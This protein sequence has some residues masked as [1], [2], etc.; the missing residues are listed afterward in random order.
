M[1]SITNYQVHINFLKFGLDEWIDVSRE[2]GRRRVTHAFTHTEGS[3]DAHVREVQDAQFRVKLNKSGCKVFEVENDGNCLFRAVALQILGDVS[4][5]A[6]VRKKC[7]EHLAKHRSHFKNFVGDDKSFDSYVFVCCFSLS[8]SLFLSNTHTHTHTNRYLIRM[9][10]DCVWGGHLEIIAMEEIWDRQIMIYRSDDTNDVPKPQ[11][12]TP[13]QLGEQVTPILLSYHGHSHY[14]ALTNVRSS[15]SF[16]LP[17]RPTKILL[18][19]RLLE[20]ATAPGGE[21]KEEDEEEEEEEEDE[22]EKKEEETPT[23]D[24]IYAENRRKAAGEEKEEEEKNK[25]KLEKIATTDD[26]YSEN[27][28]NAA[29]TPVMPTT[30]ATTEAYS[31]HLT[32]ST[33]PP[34]IVPTSIQKKEVTVLEEDKGPEWGGDVSSS[35]GED[36]HKVESLHKA[37]W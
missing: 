28:M 20:N 37:D 8:L 31:T 3:A 29:V 33:M 9:S 22:K 11:S 5:H 32:T 18:E 2:P 30:T 36:T 23:T 27:R 34:P 13:V 4:M 26:I 17:H 21:N 24:D 10:K 16:P 7:C 14:N 15:V 35:T 12:L 25:K 19:A 1:L 6:V